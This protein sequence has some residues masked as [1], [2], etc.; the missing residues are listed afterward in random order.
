MVNRQAKRL[1]PLARL[2]SSLKH[3]DVQP[4]RLVQ[5]AELLR[6]AGLV[7]YV[8]DTSLRKDTK[9]KGVRWRIPGSKDYAG[10]ILQ[11]SLSYHSRHKLID[12]NTAETYACN[13]ELARKVVELLDTPPV[14]CAA[15]PDAA[16]P[17]CDAEGCGCC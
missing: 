2:R 7:V 6:E 8:S 1:T 13:R 10:K 5:M 3:D 12:H 17:R 9:P 4:P 14:A 15:C 11:V 16:H